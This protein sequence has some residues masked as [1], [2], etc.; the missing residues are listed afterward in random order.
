MPRAVAARRRGGRVASMAALLPGGF[1]HGERVMTL[2]ELEAFGAALGA[3]AA[4]ALPVVI[5]LS[6][7]LGAG[8][9]TLTRAIGHGYGVL[10]PVTSPTYAL[11][12]EYAAA[13][14]RHFHHVDLYRLKGPH[15]LANIGWEGLFTDQALTVVEWPDRAGDLLPGDVVSIALA[16]VEGDET[17]RRV[18]W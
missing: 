7:D 4:T 14:G 10:E 6:G 17:R 1:A 12:H 18:I 11:V 5:T 2:D 9:T 13:G 16:H 8:K 15:E 3:A